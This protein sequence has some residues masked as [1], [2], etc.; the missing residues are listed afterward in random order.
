MRVE[1][2]KL[3]RIFQLV[4]DEGD[5]FF[6]ELNRLV[7][8]KNIRAGSVF[9]FGALNKTDMIAGFRSLKGYDI[10]RRHLGD[11]RELLGLGNITWPEKPPASMGDV[12][13]SE[14]QPYV[15]IHMALSGGPGKT[16]KV[17]VGH[18]SGGQVQGI[19]TDIYEFV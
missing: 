15:H 13:W 10:D 3:D 6:G 2:R 19:L 8:E 7:K 5:D 14:P 18:L 1:K 11:R 4:F 16:D 12:T 9:V 17:L